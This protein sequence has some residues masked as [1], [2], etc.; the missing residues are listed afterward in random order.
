M[1]AL[2]IDNK[3]QRKVKCCLCSNEEFKT[4]YSFPVNRFDHE[5]YITHSW[6]GGLN[7]PLTIVSCKNCGFIYQNPIFKDEHLS[8]LYPES[9][10]PE[11]LGA[12]NFSENFFPLWNLINP[13]LGEGENFAVDIGARF[14]AMSAF[15]QKKG[16]NAIGIE[17][18]PACVKAA[19]DF[20]IKGMHVGR[21]NDLPAILDLHGRKNVD[22]ITMVDVIE[23]LTEPSADFKIISSVQ[24]SGQLLIMTTMFAD[25]V[26]RYLFGKEWYY[27]H[28]QHT[29]YFSKKDIKNFLE[30]YGYEVVKINF[31]PYYKNL[32]PAPGEIVKYI[33]HKLN[34]ILNTKYS[35]KK[36]F[37]ADRPHCLD[38]M[39]VIAIKK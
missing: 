2:S 13:Y 36:W 21:I 3:Y 19:T 16:I 4:L 10:I 24:V 26:G 38:L 32:K 23:H 27:I 14:G 17:M 22:L 37:A 28:A 8:F 6:D 9:I 11:K 18:N 39:T 25:S 30:K 1:E 20:G 35:P 15:F 5:S 34:L 7:V 29:L 33:K 31:I 12:N